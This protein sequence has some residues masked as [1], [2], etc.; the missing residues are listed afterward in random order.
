MV[1]SK[2]S[3]SKIEETAN[4]IIDFITSRQMLPGDKMPTEPVLM[5]DLNV[6]RSTLREAIRTL[7]ARNILEVRQ[8]SGTF[9]SKR[10]GVPL[11]PLGL[12][13][14]YDDDRLAIDLL[15][16]RLMIEPQTAL[17]AAL[18]ATEE[19]CQELLK[20][21]ALVEKLIQANQDY[22]EEDIALHMMIAEASGNRVLSN[23][24]YILHTSVK[25]N[26]V[27]TE[28]ALRDNNTLV[29]HR[30]LVD[31]IVRHDATGAYN[32]MTIH[33]TMLWEFISAKLNSK[34]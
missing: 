20:Q 25:K 17:L 23:L 13:F 34:E 6:S 3:K 28:D 12:T 7:S 18:H 14:I 32:A 8:G 16:V 11:D 27:S 24:S 29:Y 9:I 21:C 26:I 33:V 2:S 15:D 31:A 10:C 19:Q 22:E 5:E 1:N 4:N 30:R